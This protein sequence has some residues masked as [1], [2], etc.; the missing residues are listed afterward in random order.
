MAEEQGLSAEAVSI[1]DA[2]K[3]DYA[4]RHGLDVARLLSDRW[5]GC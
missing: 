4:L 2:F 5:A 3:R 1:S